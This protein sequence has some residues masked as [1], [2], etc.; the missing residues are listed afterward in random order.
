MEPQQHGL[1]L[2]KAQPVRSSSCPSMPTRPPLLQELQHLASKHRNLV[3]IPLGRCPEQVPAR[4]ASLPSTTDLASA[5]VLCTPGAQSREAAVPLETPV[6]PSP[7]QD[8]RD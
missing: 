7:R 6:L 8:V 3:I 4:F 2:R 5:L 1:C